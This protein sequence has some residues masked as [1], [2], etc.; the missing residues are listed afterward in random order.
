MPS[1]LHLMQVLLDF[2]R[3]INDD[4]GYAP[5]CFWKYFVL[6]FTLLYMLSAACQ[7]NRYMEIN[8]NLVPN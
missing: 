4:N 5:L 1:S 6:L 2:I 8:M 3:Q 7:T